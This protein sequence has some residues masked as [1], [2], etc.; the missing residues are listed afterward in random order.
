VARSR[1]SPAALPAFRPFQLAT[2]T[3][4]V[5]EGDGWLFEIKFDGYRCEAAIASGQV[6]LYSRGGHDWT[7]KFGFV[8]PALAKLPGSALI[9]GEVCALDDEGRSDFSKLKVSLDGKKPLVFFAFDLLEQDGRDISGLHQIER[10]RRLAELLAGLPEGSPVQYVDHVEGNGQEFFEA[11]RRMRLEGI[12]AKSATARY[13]GGDRSTAWLKIKSVQRQ[14]FVIIGWRPPDRGVTPVDVRALFLATFEGGQL[15][16][17]GAVGTGFS[18]RDRRDLKALFD[19]MP[20][21]AVQVS[22]MPAAERRKCQWIEPRLLA[23][24]AFTEI[25]PDGVIRH[26]SFK[27]IREDKAA[28]EAHL[29]RPGRR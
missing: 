13:Y 25:T 12:I 17:R 29:E 21:A 20:S 28:A 19:T 15:V 11:A 14:E 2:L 8:A 5:P 16:Y 24:V 4:H 9:D 18:D 6:R 27:G 1:Q 23:E 10:K 26:P 7:D 3:E 22:G